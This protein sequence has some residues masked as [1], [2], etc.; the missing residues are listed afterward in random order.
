MS[1]F[2]IILSA[3][4]EMPRPMTPEEYNESLMK[5]I[6]STPEGE[7]E[8]EPPDRPKVEEKKTY[9]PGWPKKIEL[10]DGSIKIFHSPEEWRKST[11][12]R[13]K[14]THVAPEETPTEPAETGKYSDEE[15]KRMIAEDPSH[16]VTNL[17]LQRK[18]EYK[19]F[20]YDMLK[21]LV[22]WV[23]DSNISPKKGTVLY[24]EADYMLNEL[25]KNLDEK[26]LGDTDSTS[27]DVQSGETEWEYKGR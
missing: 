6:Y 11:E 8:W 10:P 26:E 14:K 7:S 4:D 18:P 2:S 19:K 12:E 5:G 15:V 24:D 16:V 17:M 3:T 22:D 20:M 25:N 13:F 9:E 27:P 21:S 23:T 1:E